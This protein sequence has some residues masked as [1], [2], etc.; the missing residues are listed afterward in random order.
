MEGFFDKESLKTIEQD[1]E[2]YIFALK[3]SNVIIIVN[4][5]LEIFFIFNMNGNEKLTT[6]T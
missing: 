6:K 3:L 5:D 2:K 1:R 4:K